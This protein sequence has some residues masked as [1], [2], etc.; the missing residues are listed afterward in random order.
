MMTTGPNC[1]GTS[2]WHGNTV[3]VPTTL[4]QQFGYVSSNDTGY[5]SGLSNTAGTQWGCVS[6]AT[7]ASPLSGCSTYYVA[8]R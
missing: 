3:R 2:S 1:C 6:N 5:R 8:C 7:A 4:G